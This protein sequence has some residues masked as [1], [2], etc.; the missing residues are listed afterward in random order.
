MPVRHALSKEDQ[1]L[2]FEVGQ[3]RYN[4]HSARNTPHRWNRPPIR[5]LN[6]EVEAIGAEIATARVLG[7]DWQDKSIEEDRDGDIQGGIQVRFTNY[8]T[9]RLLL[10]D[11]DN[12]DHVFFLVTGNYPNYVV[13]GWVPCDEG[14]AVGSVRELQPG[15]PAICVEQEDLYSVKYYNNERKQNGL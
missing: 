6:L 3:N 8:P 9:G 7:L 10:H 2:A 11:S 13:Q 14:K 5:D 4:Y 15:R 1:Q 12:D